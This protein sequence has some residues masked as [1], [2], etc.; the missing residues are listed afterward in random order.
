MATAQDIQNSERLLDLSNQLIDSINERKKALKGITAEEQLYFSTVKQQQK[1]SQD[2]AANAEKYLGYQIK[3]KDLTK[4][5][6]ATEDN[7]NK[8]KNA[9]AAIEQKILASKNKAILEARK[10]NQ[11]DRTLREQL[12][13]LEEDSNDLQTQKQEALRTGN[14]NLARQLQKYINENNINANNIDKII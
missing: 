6:K 12:L 10:L 9:Y 4:Q 11:Q 3:S 14:V 5:I 7:I 2:I 8:S 13:R 1:L